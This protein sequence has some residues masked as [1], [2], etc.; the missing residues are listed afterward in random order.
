MAANT[1]VV[2]SASITTQ[3]EAMV[4]FSFTFGNFPEVMVPKNPASGSPAAGGN[5]VVGVR[6]DLTPQAPAASRIPESESYDVA[7]TPTRV[8]R[9]PDDLIFQIDRVSR[10][11]AECIRLG[12]FALR[13]R[14]DPDHVLRELGNAPTRTRTDLVTPRSASLKV[15]EPEADSATVTS[16]RTTCRLARSADDLISQIDLVDRSI[17]ECIRLGEDALHHHDDSDRIPFGLRDAAATYSD[18]IRVRLP[19]LATL[20]QI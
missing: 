12:E 17:A 1:N 2:F 9:R 20:G 11:I 13:H 5:V 16:S 15:P 8:T 19:D 3:M 7:A 6:S 14:N 18:Q 4:G 10:S